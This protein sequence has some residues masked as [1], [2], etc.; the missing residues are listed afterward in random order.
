MRSARRR[1]LVAL[2]AGWPAA[3]C[4]TGLW[5][6]RA[7][8]TVTGAAYCVAGDPAGPIYAGGSY[9]SGSGT[10]IPFLRRYS[11]YGGPLWTVTMAGAGSPTYEDAVRGVAIYPVSGTTYDVIA[12]GVFWNALTSSQDAFV[13]RL[14]PYGATVWTDFLNPSSGGSDGANAV[15]VTPAGEIVVAGWTAGTGGVPDAYVWKLK[16]DGTLDDYTAY[17]VPEPAGVDDRALAVAVDSS[18]SIYVGGYVTTAGEG[19]NAWVAQ[20]AATAALGLPLWTVTL[21]G[22]GSSTDFVGGLA[23]DPAGGLYAVGGAAGAVGWRDILLVRTT[24]DGALVWT[25]TLDGGEGDNDEADGCTVAAGGDLLV[26]GS[27]DRPTDT[28]SDLWIARFGADGTVRWE[29]DR[30]GPGYYIDGG[31]GIAT[32]PAGEILVAGFESDLATG[33]PH[34]WLVDFR[35]TK[36]GPVVSPG[37]PTPHATPNPF[38]PGSGGSFDA[39]G[40]TF[41]SVPAGAKLR[42]YSIAGALVV[43]LR[44]EDRDG[45]IAWDARNSSGKDVS[46]GVYLFVVDSGSGTPARGKVV[47]I[48]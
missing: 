11:P 17:P 20:Y 7:E 8:T 43:E 12:A 44:D 27:I 1:F 47:I 34:P 6:E 3:S 39:S 26:T 30:N 28:F 18:G 40:V 14:T 13:A 5:W 42:I 25:L 16:G 2:V 41:R 36:S 15:A 37:P 10:T 21:N 48:R 19:T 33:L 22:A 31:C 32:N 9:R 29:F 23:V 38:R 35:E 45:L 24:L 4:A 46:S